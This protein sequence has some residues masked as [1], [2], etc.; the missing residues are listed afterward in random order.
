MAVHCGWT[1]INVI[2]WH[3]RRV[4][5][6][7]N[8]ETKRDSGAY[9]PRRQTKGIT[10]ETHV[11]DCTH[12][13]FDTH[14]SSWRFVGLRTR[15]SRRRQRGWRRISRRGRRRWFPRRSR[16]RRWCDRRRRITRREFRRWEFRRWEFRRWTARRKPTFDAAG[17]RPRW[18]L[19]EH[20]RARRQQSPR[21]RRRTGHRES[22]RNRR[23]ARNRKS[24][25]SR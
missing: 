5:L 7:H 18:E 11:S 19:T 17:R 21:I 13:L 23:S 2:R 20:R 22:S 10:H 9:Q 15:R 25:G 4:L 6:T 12:A 14:D 3:P 24:S 8:A 1:G 16:R